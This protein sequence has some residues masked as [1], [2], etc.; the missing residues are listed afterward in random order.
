MYTFVALTLPQLL[1]IHKGIFKYT[2]YEK[3]FFC[4]LTQMSC[5]GDCKAHQPH[6]F[7]GR[8]C[9]YGVVRTNQDRFPKDLKISF[10][11]PIITWPPSINTFANDHH[12]YWPASI[13]DSLIF[14]EHIWSPDFQKMSK[15]QLW[16]PEK[17]MI[18]LTACLSLSADKYFKFSSGLP[19]YGFDSW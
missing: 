16:I 6:Q 3:R 1:F 2:R 5:T 10:S 12:F 9:L 8:H 19:A 14:R 18:I 13:L 17:A 7:Q 4:C 11:L 15:K